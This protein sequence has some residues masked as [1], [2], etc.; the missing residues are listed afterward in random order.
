MILEIRSAWFTEEEEEEEEDE[1]NLEPELALAF[2]LEDLELEALDDFL[3]LT[4]TNPF[5][6]SVKAV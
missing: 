5:W 6:V 3:A 1:E 2:E 4:S